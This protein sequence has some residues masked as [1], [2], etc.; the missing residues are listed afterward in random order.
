MLHYLTH[1]KGLSINS[2][3]RFGE[4]VLASLICHGTQ[5]NAVDALDNCASVSQTRQLEALP[6]VVTNNYILMPLSSIN[7]SLNVTMGG[8]GKGL[9]GIGT[10]K[11]KSGENV[12]AMRK[13]GVRSVD[14][15]AVTST[16]SANTLRR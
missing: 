7:D 16:V 1:I 2:V 4:N 13:L 12:T 5:R 15:G 6:K 11:A 14:Q 8:H 9:S 10:G 3:N